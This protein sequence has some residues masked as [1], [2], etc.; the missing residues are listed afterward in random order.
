MWSDSY[1]LRARNDLGRHRRGSADRGVARLGG[2]VL[3]MLLSLNVCMGAPLQDEV[4]PVEVA[5]EQWRMLGNNG[6]RAV[7]QT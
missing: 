1:K 7:T 2:L 6:Y 4:V 5:R 3:D